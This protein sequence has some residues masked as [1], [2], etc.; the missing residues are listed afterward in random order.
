MV[1][2]DSFRLE[3]L[4]ALGYVIEPGDVRPEFADEKDHLPCE[5]ILAPSP[6]PAS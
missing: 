5:P 4:K 6:K 1:T 3:Q 2:L